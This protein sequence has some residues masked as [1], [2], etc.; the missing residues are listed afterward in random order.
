[1]AVSK[2]HASN[3]RKGRHSQPGQYYFLT[4]SV[5]GRRRIFTRRNNSVVVLDVIRWLHSAGRFFV[6]AAVVMPDHIHVAGQL[7]QDTLA[8]VMHTLKGYS[9]KRLAKA[10]VEI[11]VWQ[12]GYH[13][14]AL[15][16]DEDYRI[17][18]QYLID[19]P[20]RAGLVKHVRQYPFV[21]LPGWW[22]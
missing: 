10:G 19:N 21:I 22:E 16:N 6:D 13:D 12:K 8:N 3:L 11:P 1:M 7:G 2:P 14:H 20:V 15:R 9:A 17:R 4:A 5:A 18:I